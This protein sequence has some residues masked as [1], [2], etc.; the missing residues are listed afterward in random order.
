MSSTTRIKFP[1]HFEIETVVGNGRGGPV[2]SY[3]FSDC[4]RTVM[5]DFC[6]AGEIGGEYLGEFVFLSSR[7]A[8]IG[9]FNRAQLFSRYPKNLC[10]F[11][12]NRRDAFTRRLGGMSGFGWWPP[13]DHTRIWNGRA[14]DWRRRKWRRVHLSAPC[15]PLFYR[16]SKQ[17]TPR[18]KALS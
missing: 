7:W 10:R 3:S 11:L 14:G 8:T 5:E 15:N 4:P 13:P 2:D 1:C 6:K 9:D 16:T 12:L 18:D 17:I